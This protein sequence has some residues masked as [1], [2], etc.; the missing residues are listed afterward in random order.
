MKKLISI[1]LILSLAVSAVSLASCGGKHVIDTDI[2][3]ND[4]DV[5][6]GAAGYVYENVTDEKGENV[7]DA[8]GETVTVA[9]PVEEE[10]TT[11]GSDTTTKKGE[12]TTKKGETT[13]K[14]GETTTKKGETTTKKG[15]TTTKKGETT[16]KKAETTTKKQETTTKKQENTT[17]KQETT[18]K[19][20]ETT[21]AK[22]AT[23]EPPE[24]NIKDGE[25]ELSL[26][27]DKTTVHPGDTVTVTLHMKN[28]KYVGSLGLEVKAV[29][30]IGSVDSVKD[31]DFKSK[32]FSNSSGDSFTVYSNMMDKK[33]DKD[34]GTEQNGAMFGG[35]IA[36]TYDFNDADFCTVTFHV[37]EKAQK[38]ETIVFVCLPTTFLVGTDATG[39][40]VQDYSEAL[41]SKAVPITVSVE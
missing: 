39:Q 41:N 13:T 8:D 38:G 16:T 36:K 24:V 19:K 29:S 25:Y 28:C 1:V 26:K 23:T 40:T 35:M 31:G 10:G 4:A 5:V 9:V 11:A 14:K 30:K 27:A 34:E 22:P 17:K 32:S 33:V 7:T 15:E 18:T 3:G 37:T 12:T 2:A 20:P 6:S 21:T